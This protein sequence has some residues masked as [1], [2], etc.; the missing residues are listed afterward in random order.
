MAEGKVSRCAEVIS[1]GSTSVDSYLSIFVF[2]SLQ[3]N[4]PFKNISLI[5]TSQ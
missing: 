2:F 1:L 3:F 5:E 4:V